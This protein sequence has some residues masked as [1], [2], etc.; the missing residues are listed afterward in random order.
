M[1]TTKGSEIMTGEKNKGKGFFNNTEKEEKNTYIK[2][3]RISNVEPDKNQPRKEFNEEKMAELT[4]SIKMHGI[5]SPII[6]REIGGGRYTIIAGE[7]RWRASRRAGLSEI[8]A[9]IRDYTTQE[10]KEISLI[11]NLQRENLNIIEEAIGY[12]TLIEE[13][14]LTQEEVATIIGKSRPAIS[15]TLRLLTLPTSVLELVRENNISQGH[16][17]VLLSVQDEKQ[18]KNIADIIVKENLSVRE[19]EKRVNSLKKPKKAEKAK[20]ND[21]NI[22]ELEKQI[23]EKLGV[24]AK[25]SSGKIKGKIEL[26]FYNKNDFEKLIELLID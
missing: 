15:N 20:E 8:P 1:T 21:C 13:H 11:E 9:I 2:T 25:I 7:R 16:A 5:I 18:M 24:K 26:E 3:I 4:E 23:S 14:M 10:I 22:K 19:T 12:K 17:K 6:V